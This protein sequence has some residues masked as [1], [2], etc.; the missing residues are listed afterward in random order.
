MVKQYI[1]RIIALNIIFALI[2]TIYRAIF[3]FYY[4]SWSDLSQ[5][6]GDLIHAFVLGARYDCAVI[7]YINFLPTL[8]FAIFWFIGSQKLFIKFVK[9]LK[10]YFM[11]LF[12]FVITLLCIDFG[13]YSYFQNHMNILMFGIFSIVRK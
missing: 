8:F 4:S 2:M 12:G 1:K 6:L 3:T 9:S 11:L 5:Y 7:A 10:Y 13:F